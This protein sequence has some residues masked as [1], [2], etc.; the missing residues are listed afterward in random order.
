MVISFISKLRM[1]EERG[2]SFA[3]VAECRALSELG[4]DLELVLPNRRQVRDLE[5]VDF[6]NYYQIK[7]NLFQIIKLNCFDLPQIP[8][9]ENIVYHFRYLIISWSFCVSA[10]CYLMKQKRDVIYV[11]ND[12]K[13]IL[14]ALAI[15]RFFY[16]PIV[17]YE[18]HILPGQKYD[19]FLE[20]VG[21]RSVTVLVSTTHRFKRHYL[22][23]FFPNNK[24]IVYPN[25]INLEDFDYETP[26]KVLR[27][28]LYLP[29]SKIILGFG[30]RFITARMEKGL[31]ELIHATAKLIRQKMDVFLVCIGGPQEYVD[32]YKNLARELEIEDKC[33]ILPHVP[34]NKLYEY[35]RAFDICVMPFPWTKH[36]AFNMSPLKMFEYMAT[37][38]PLIATDLPVVHEILEHKKN[39]YLVKP[40]DADSLTRG[41]RNIILDSN[42]AKKI[43]EEA[44]KEVSEKYLW[45]KRQQ[46]VMNK[47]FDYEI[48]SHS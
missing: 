13:E 31:P 45:K 40:G 34:P 30:G 48:S 3:N 24:I 27:K 33:L 22:K 1:P 5:G 47:I 38:Q 35:M 42:L 29:I 9:I 43:S 10:I 14:F 46:A 25:G 4:Y 20:S 36:F 26:K 16:H 32:K 39:S 11:C 37:K 19:N 12:S 28:K 17:I 7:Q 41:I 21:L 8:L 18:V 2:M 6:W 23:N 15:V 44:Y